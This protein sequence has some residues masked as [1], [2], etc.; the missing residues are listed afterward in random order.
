MDYVA[1]K[2]IPSDAGTQVEFASKLRQIRLWAGDPSLKDLAKL[3]NG[4]L[5]K[6]TA[7]DFLNGK[8]WP[9][10]SQVRDFLVACQVPEQEHASWLETWTRLTIDPKEGVQNPPTLPYVARND[11]ALHWVGPIKQSR[12]ILLWGPPGSG[13]TCFLGALGIAASETVRPWTLIGGNPW[14]ADFISSVMIDMGRRMCF[15][16]ASMSLQSFN[17]VMH[18]ETGRSWRT[19]YRREPIELGLEIFDPPGG[20][21]AAR[22]GYSTLADSVLD[23]LESVH[24]I[25]L[26]FDPVRERVVGDAHE[27]FLWMI[28]R[29]AER[30][31]SR[32]LLARSRLPH[33]LAVCVSKC[34]EPEVLKYASHA[35]HLTTVYGKPPFIRDGQAKRF[36]EELCDSMPDDGARLVKQ[37]IRAYFLPERVS[38][39]ATS[40]IGFYRAPGQAF[41]T[42]DSYNIIK[43][44]AKAWRLRGPIRPINVVEPLLD[45]YDSNRR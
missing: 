23:L 25:V 41:T 30:M 2:V 12:R 40:S 17:A 27:Y 3:T 1:G 10:W 22:S 36:F 28:H 45:L 32:N 37:A 24:G 35:G 31:Q 8:R 4:R 39:F 18:L 20:T 43:D 13:K 26:F 38:Y 11:E 14:S 33:R 42:D 5:P 6:S 29:L 21:F 34:D 16:N 19:R 7:S 9:K 15:P 44:E